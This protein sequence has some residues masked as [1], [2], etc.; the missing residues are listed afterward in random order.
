MIVMFG[1]KY[2]NAH[3]LIKDK[4]NSNESASNFDSYIQK[5]YESYQV[6]GNITDELKDVTIAGMKRKLFGI[7]L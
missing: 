4:N 2:G 1:L 6:L 5:T 7:E 3:E